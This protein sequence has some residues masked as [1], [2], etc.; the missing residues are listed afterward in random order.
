MYPETE[1]QKKQEKQSSVKQSVT[2]LE[3]KIKLNQISFTTSSAL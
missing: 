2:K 1:K 3:S